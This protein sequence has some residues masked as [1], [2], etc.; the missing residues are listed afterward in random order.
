MSAFMQVAENTSPD[1]DLWITMEGWDG[2]VYQTSIPLQQASPTT[3]A[4]LKKQG[5]TP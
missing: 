5:A 4:W 2:T 3:V 1:S